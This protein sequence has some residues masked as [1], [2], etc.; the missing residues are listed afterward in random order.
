M[1]LQ[2]YSICI[3]IALACFAVKWVMAIVEVNQLRKEKHDL[4]MKLWDSKP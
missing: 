1:I 4:Q 3:T 2:I